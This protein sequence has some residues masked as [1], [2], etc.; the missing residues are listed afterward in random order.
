MIRHVNSSAGDKT[1]SKLV[2]AKYAVH[3]M[4]VY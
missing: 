3:R 2:K 4:L 1:D